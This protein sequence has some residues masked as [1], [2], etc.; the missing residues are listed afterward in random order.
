[1]DMLTDWYQQLEAVKEYLCQ[2]DPQLQVLFTAVDGDRFRL[3]TVIK[4]AY[5][6]LVAAI[7]GQKISYVTAKKLRGQLYAR[8]GLSFTPDQLK[9]ADL[10]FLGTSAAGTIAAVTNYILD[11]NIDLSTETNIRSL[12]AVQGIGPWTVETTLL[13]C[14]AN[15]DIFPQGD[16]FLQKNMKRLYGPHC[17][18]AA[19][20]AR[21]TPY[22]SV[23]TWY[24]W[25]WF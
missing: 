1:M 19:I 14:L 23:V 22:R 6:A 15:W 8:Y 3:H 5:T 20:S 18:I 2:Q 7:I 13:T 10:S 16:K 25:R 11:H 24:L 4:S 21:W 9:S 12:E 17:D